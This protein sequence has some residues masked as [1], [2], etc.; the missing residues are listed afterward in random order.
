MKKITK[1]SAHPDEAEDKKLFGSMLKKALPGKK[2]A[3][4]L[5]EDIKEQKHGIKKDKSLMTKVQR[6]SYG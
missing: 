5:R 3:K 6:G 4:H 1:K 2:I